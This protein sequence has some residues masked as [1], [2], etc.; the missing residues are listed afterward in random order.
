MIV[1]GSA[2]KAILGYATDEQTDLI[3]LGAT[4]KSNLKRVMMG[5]TAEKVLC[6][7]PC[8]LFIVR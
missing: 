5:S 1:W 6:A 8:S 4:G 3:I 2:S 7:T